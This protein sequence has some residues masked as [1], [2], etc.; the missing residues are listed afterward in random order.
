[1]LFLPELQDITSYSNVVSTT[2]RGFNVPHKKMS[3]PLLKSTYYTEIWQPDRQGKCFSSE[4]I[5]QQFRR[6]LGTTVLNGNKV[7][8]LFRLYAAFSNAVAGN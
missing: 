7:K 2:V 6:V 5:K 8:A 1:M 3:L 4:Q